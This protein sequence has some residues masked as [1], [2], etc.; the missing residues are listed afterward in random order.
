[1]QTESYDRVKDL[2]RTNPS[3]RSGAVVMHPAQPWTSTTHALLRH[4]ETVGYPAS[5]RVV[6]TG[7]DEEGSEV[8]GRFGGEILHECV[9][10]EPEESLFTVGAMLRDLHKASAGFIEPDDAVWMPWTLRQTGT[11]TVYSHGNVAPW[12]VVFRDRAPVGFIGWEYAGPVD[13][14][15]EVVATGWFC[16]QLVDDDVAERVGLPD[17][18]ERGLCLKALLDGYELARRAREDLM[19]TM[20]EFAVADTGWFA[21]TQDFTPESTEAEHLWLFS[22]QSRS[23]LWMLEH[24]NQLTRIITS[25]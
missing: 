1:M 18:A 14:M 7:F 22:W 5:Q 17:A 4:L 19:T 3:W 21:R 9:W 6:G 2:S 8:L 12:H 20:V 25:R 11:G 23:A 24:R 15:K 10:P 16:A 13:P